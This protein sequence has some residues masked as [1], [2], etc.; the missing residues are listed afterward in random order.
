[1]RHKQAAMA[2]ALAAPLA[3]TVWCG[4]SALAAVSSQPGSVTATAYRWGVPGSSG[5]FTQLER[6]TPTAVTGI[7]GKVVAIATSNSDSYALTSNGEVW[8]WGVDNYGELG[9]GTVKPD[10]VQAVRVSFPEGVKIVALAN[11]MP[12]DGALAID[13]NGHGWGW[14]L[15]ADGD[16]CLPSLPGLPASIETRPTRLPLTGVTLATGALAHSL[17]YSGGKVYACG[18][19]KDGV[20]G[21]GSTAGS[22]T[23]V[24]VTGLPAGT[25]VTALTSSWE[26]SG[27]LLAN[28]AYYDWGYNAAGQL[29]DGRTGTAT[30][31]D[32]PVQVKLPSAVRRVFQG[33]SGATNGQTIA[34]LANGSVWTWGA[35][36]SG[37]LG[38]GTTASSD[39]PLPVHVPAGVTF[40]TV[41]SGGYASYAIDSQGRLWAWGSNDYGQLGTGTSAPMET[42]P[43]NVGVHLTQVSSTARNVAGF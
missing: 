30:N 41:T 37:Q 15:N 42:T 12:F 21:T 17:F 22:S 6:T 28:G 33:G 20:L 8:A 16:L 24:P 5:A 36:K 40:V 19:G 38:N 29:G 23:P 27:A 32:L 26:G 10:S 14:G 13:S 11:P 1:M 35:N 25:R 31:S 7:E 3:F 2:L 43:A 4:T 39:I 18:S 9:N 34:I